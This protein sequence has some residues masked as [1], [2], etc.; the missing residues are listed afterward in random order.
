MKTKLKSH[1]P[2]CATKIWV[3]RL[4]ATSRAGETQPPVSARVPDHQRHD[5]PQPGSIERLVVADQALS[6]VRSSRWPASPC[7]PADP[8]YQS[9]CDLLLRSDSSE[10]SFQNSLEPVPP[11]GCPFG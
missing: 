8:S 1:S 7:F 2:G 4:M 6:L 11:A 10:W 3:K 9:G 5:T